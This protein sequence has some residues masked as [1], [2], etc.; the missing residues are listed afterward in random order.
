MGNS[1]RKSLLAILARPF[2]PGA[3]KE[4]AMDDEVQKFLAL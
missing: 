4:N 3:E 2:G 1:R